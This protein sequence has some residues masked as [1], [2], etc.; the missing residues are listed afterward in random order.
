MNFISYLTRPQ[1]FILFVFGLPML[2]YISV[3]YALGLPPL[4]GWTGF[5]VFIYAMLALIGTFIYYLGQPVIDTF[6]KKFPQEL[7]N[8][9]RIFPTL[10]WWRKAA[11]IIFLVAM[12]AI[13]VLAIVRIYF[14][15]YNFH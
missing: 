1:K 3:F 12:V 13:P 11:A 15:I 9:F 14:F 4:G 8:G 7:I 2:I 5:A 6:G 10:S